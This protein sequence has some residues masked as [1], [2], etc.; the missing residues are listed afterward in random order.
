MITEPEIAAGVDEPRISPAVE[1]FLQALSAL[2][3]A[4]GIVTT[5]HLAASLGVRD[6]SVTTMAKRLHALGLV[7]HTPYRGLRLTPAGER[8][9]LRVA[10]R[11]QLLERALAATLGLSPGEAHTEAERLEHAVGRSLEA[12]LRAVVDHRPA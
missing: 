7:V 9:T 5:S 3:G 4:E 1:Q 8:V 11:H 10:H 2:E 6:P 12:R